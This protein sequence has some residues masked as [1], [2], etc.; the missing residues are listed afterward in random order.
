MINSRSIGF[1]SLLDFPVTLYDSVG[2]SSNGNH[3]VTSDYHNGTFIEH[4]DTWNLGHK[5]ILPEIADSIGFFGSYKDL[6]AMSF[7]DRLLILDRYSLEIFYRC[8]IRPGSLYIPP[9]GR[10]SKIGYVDKNGQTCILHEDNRVEKSSLNVGTSS[11]YDVLWSNTVAPVGYKSIEDDVVNLYI[12]SRKEDK[13]NTIS[14]SYGMFVHTVWWNPHMKRHEV[15]ITTIDNMSILKRVTSSA[16]G[17]VIE[18]IAALDKGKEITDLITLSDGQPALLVGGQGTEVVAKPIPPITNTAEMLKN[19]FVNSTDKQTVKTIG[20]TLYTNWKQNPASP[21]KLE[22]VNYGLSGHP[23]YEV[24]GNMPH[25]AVE[26]AVNHVHTMRTKDK[27]IISYRLVSPFS[28]KKHLVET[29]VIIPDYEGYIAAGEYSPTVRLCYN[30]GIAVA[31]VPTRILK[32]KFTMN[33]YKLDLI[34]V[35]YDI[36][37][38]K[39][40]KNIIVLGNKEYASIALDAMQDRK[41]YI[42]EAILIDPPHEV[43]KK[44]KRKKRSAVSIVE[45]ADDRTISDANNYVH[46]LPENSD[47]DYTKEIAS[48]ILR[49]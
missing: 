43:L 45:T 4:S 26:P 46:H 39:I 12:R 1:D 7:N 17:P 5:K 24:K 36:K 8:T 31:I 6:I 27:Q 30:A 25:D 15:Y 40:A 23:T 47:R 42:K 2:V 3:I 44:I 14:S 49:G 38:K 41:S 13:G 48:I 33:D 37:S 34:D 32:N 20:D 9:I 10:S 18:E 21:P 29:V 11:K 28:I 16:N 35:A 19:I 22:V